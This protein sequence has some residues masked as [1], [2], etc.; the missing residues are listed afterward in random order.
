MQ[1]SKIYEMQLKQ[2][3]KGSLQ[4]YI[5]QPTPVFL[6]GESQGWWGLVGFH[7]W[8]RTELDTTEATQ[9]QQQHSNIG[10]AQDI[11]KLS[12]K[13]PNLPLER[14]GKGNRDKAKCQQKEGNKKNQGRYN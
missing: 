2:F 10:P 6:P 4:Q 5:W 13:L 3:D 8:G 1:L 9:Q 12:N 11:W 14:T 7:L